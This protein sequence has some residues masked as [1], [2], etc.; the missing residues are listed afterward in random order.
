MRFSL[1]TMEKVIDNKIQMTI[2]GIGGQ[3]EEVFGDPM[4]KRGMSLIGSQGGQANADKTLQNKI[5]MDILNGPQF[6]GLKII[7]ST[8]GLNVDEYIEDHG[9]KSTIEAINSLS[10][11][12]PGMDL[13]SIM[14]G[15]MNP[16]VGHEANNTKNPYI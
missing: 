15:G 9:A 2:D 7:A 14:K 8:L 4:V 13:G 1:A 6:A 3:L 5:A 16:S 11:L 10:G 12:I